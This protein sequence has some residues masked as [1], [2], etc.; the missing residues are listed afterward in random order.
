MKAINQ[1]TLSARA[2]SKSPKLATLT[3]LATACAML[4][5]APVNAAETN[6]GAA[7]T[8]TTAT[9]VPSAMDSSKRVIRLARP[10]AASTAQEGTFRCGGKPI[11]NQLTFKA[12]AFHKALLCQ[13]MLSRI[14]RQ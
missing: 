14:V 9:S 11:L 1:S 6:A 10:T 7:K 5:S 3:A 13:I 12:V 4:L 8:D 2:S